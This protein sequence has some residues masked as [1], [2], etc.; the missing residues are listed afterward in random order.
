M[1]TEK[2]PSCRFFTVHRLVICD[3][4]SEKANFIFGALCH[5]EWHLGMRTPG[6]YFS[7]GIIKIIYCMYTYICSHRYKNDRAL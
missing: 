5:C 2:K 6:D 1:T 4:S 7:E 3:V